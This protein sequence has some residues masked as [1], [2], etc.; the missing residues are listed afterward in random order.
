MKQ[1]YDVSA[2][3][4]NQRIYIIEYPTEHYITH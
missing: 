3:K 1:Y 4:K 2:V